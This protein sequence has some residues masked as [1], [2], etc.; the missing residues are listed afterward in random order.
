MGKFANKEEGQGMRLGPPVHTEGN[1]GFDALGK[2]VPF[3]RQDAAYQH[4]K[5]MGCTDKEGMWNCIGRMSNAIAR[6]EP[7]DALETAINYVDATGAYRLLA[8]LLTAEAP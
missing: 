6:D 3:Y 8:V 4:M 5:D 2:S 7:H 1:S